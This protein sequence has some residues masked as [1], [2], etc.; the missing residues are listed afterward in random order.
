VSRIKLTP[1]TGQP[2]TFDV[3]GA[4]G[5]PFIPRTTPVSGGSLIGCN[6]TITLVHHVKGDDDDIY[7]CHTTGKASWFSK[8]TITTAADGAKPVNTYEVRVFGEL[9][10]VI[11]AVG[12]YVVKGVIDSLATPSELK[13]TEHFRI[14]AISDN[15]RG[16][17]AHWRFS[18]Q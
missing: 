18:G 13:N 15:R 10:G 12:D 7:E 9:F 8:N 2:D 4:N 17:L 3:T 14:T 5:Q 11:P 16:N 1:V 6:E